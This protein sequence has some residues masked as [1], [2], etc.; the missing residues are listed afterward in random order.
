MAELTFQ[1]PGV[2]LR[3]VDL[4]GPT[5]VSPVGTPAGVIGTSTRGPAF[6][7]V[8]VANYQQFVSVFGGTDGQQ[9]AP[10]AMYEWL[11]NAQAGLF[12]RTLGAGD[13]R[14]R[15]L[16]GDNAGKVR[17]AGFVVGDEQVQANGDVGANPFAVGDYPG[18]THF[19][20]CFMSES[21]GSTMLSEAGMQSGPQAAPVIRGVMMTPAG[22]RLS[23]SGSSEHSNTLPL[24]APA[25]DI[26]GFMT[27]AVRLADGSQNFTLFLS[28]HIANDQFNNRIVASFDPKSPAYFAKIF[29]TDP[30]KIEEAGH[31][32]YAHYDIHGQYAVPTGSDI[33]IGAW[34]PADG[35]EDIAFVLNGQA[36]HNSGSTTLPNFE[37]FEDRFR[38]ALSPWV[39]SQKFGG[40]SKDLF[41]VHTLDD[42]QWPNNRVKIS[43][44]NITPSTDPT[45]EFGTFD[46]FVRDFRDTDEN[47]IVLESFTG[48]SLNP[49]SQRYVARIIG[50]THTFYDFDRSAGSQKLVIDGLYPNVS[51]YI[52]VEV[53]DSLRDEEVPASALPFGFRGLGRLVTQNV[54]E[55]DGENAAELANTAQPPVP[56]R[57]TI[58][59][60]SG[61]AI[62]TLPFAHWGVQFE[63]ND[64]IIEPNKNNFSDGTISSFTK[65]FP[66]FHTNWRKA[67]ETDTAAN[68]TFN[69]NLFSLDQV[70]VYTAA[71]GFPNSNLWVSASYSRDPQAPSQLDRHLEVND[72][73][74]SVTR[75]FAKFT[76]PVQG[77]FDGVNIFNRE[78]ARMSDVAAKREMDY[79]PTQGGPEGATVASYRKAVDILGER[80]DVDIQL[81]AI[82]G[83]REPGVIDY[84]ISAIESRFDALLI[85]DIPE[86]NTANQVITSSDD[87]PSV[88]LTVNALVNR[89]LDTSFAAAYFPD[90]V[91][92][93]PT[94][95]T[96]IVAP[97]S[98]AVLGAFALNDR[99]AYPWFA[100]AGFTR[101]ALSDVV[102]AQVKLNRTNLD[103]LYS[104]NINPITSV[105]TSISPIVFGQ[106]TLL[107]RQ[108]SLDRVN[109][110]RL[111]IE[112][113]RRVRRASNAI[114]FE[115]N[116]EDT[117]ERFSALVNPVLAQI[118]AQQGVDRFRVRIDTSTTTQVDVENNTIRGKIFVQPT[119]T[120][121]FVSLDFVVTNAGAEI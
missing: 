119:R 114:I 61:N 56:F 47:P 52:R 76:F 41:R 31:Y 101:G 37:S 54:L 98:I 72:L 35:S 90:V 88:G 16:S 65:Y 59:A 100:P 95:K 120:I 11:K 60:G 97:P 74:D 15:V 103:T 111:L 82:P 71:N 46:L 86:R 43:I 83:I 85:A 8:V 105:P 87:S 44:R 102:E 28:G 94:T 118:Q 66:S 75:R 63:V 55:V 99:V 30:T 106:K 20:G 117:L 22:V 45:S 57:R 24:N 34:S 96:N 10:L 48:M 107:A 109:V 49:S 64:S 81:M 26:V 84:A 113:R 19:I 115:P 108:S 89:S 92:T 9:F 62:R 13:G 29:N 36:S 7:P 79:I 73:K 32:L 116:R 80:S 23:L 121:E 18:R 1:S 39:V 69:N 38:T 51:N 5:D 4:S 112:I 27:G 68:D 17:H 91:I 40:V 50:D 110:R 21:A 77:G 70:Q 104:A 33:S 14:S 53:S 93:D 3:E 67:W 6:V 12:V 2:G 25:P 42:G 78:K 58:T